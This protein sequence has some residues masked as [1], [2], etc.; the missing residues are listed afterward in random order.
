M[1]K[2]IKHIL[3]TVALI[4]CIVPAF[5]QTKLS[6]D[7]R[8]FNRH[9][10]KA[11]ITF[12]FPPGFKEVKLGDNH[13]FDYAISSTDDD[14]EIWFKVR[15]QRENMAEYLRKSDRKITN[16]DSVYQDIALA[17]A[18]TFKSKTDDRPLFIRNI[19][20]YTLTRY[21][22]DIGKTYLIN[23]P[24]DPETKHHK[25]AMLVVLQKNKVGTI[26]A[27]CFANELG[28][29]FFKTLNE[30]SSCLKFN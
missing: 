6:S 2:Q 28:P 18:N 23:L 29:G 20:P 19:P 24:D 27:V 3:N 9:L 17:Q 12:T 10:A 11:N 14:C 30:A 4:L 1:I 8:V 16:P 5:A 21:N 25:F 7:N 26:M 13:A 15:S 22:A